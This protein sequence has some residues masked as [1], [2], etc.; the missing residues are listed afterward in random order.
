MKRATRAAALCGIAWA[1]SGCVAAI[2]PVIAAGAIGRKQLKHNTAPD[3]PGANPQAVATPPATPAPAA[4]P[5]PAP[6]VTASRAEEPQA[7][8]VAPAPTPTAAPA[9]VAGTITP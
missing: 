9:P 7:V 3:L 5:A 4:A 8:A 2:V 6:I 1:L